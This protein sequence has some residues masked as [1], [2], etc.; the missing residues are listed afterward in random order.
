MKRL[1]VPESSNAL[2]QV[3]ADLDERLNRLWRHGSHM[4][5][6]WMEAGDGVAVL[7]APFEGLVDI[8]E[9]E[10]GW[11]IAPHRMTPDDMKRA[12][13]ALGVR[14]TK[15]PL[16]S[17]LDEHPGLAG[18]VETMMC[19]YGVARSQHRAGVMFDIVDF[20]KKSA[21]E[22]VLLIKNLSY[23]INVAHAR[24]SE[25][26]YDI[27]LGRA[28]TASGIMIWNRRNGL[29]ADIHLFYLMILTLADNALK[30]QGKEE[31]FIP[32]LRTVFH[33]GPVY[34]FHQPQGLAPGAFNL[35]FGGLVAAL[36]HVSALARPDQILATQFK[37]PVDPPPGS[38]QRR[39]SA[40]TPQFI[41]LAQREIDG[42]GDVLLE[43]E[44]VSA[45]KCYLTGR[46]IGGG[47]F[48]IL[49]Y[50]TADGLGQQHLLFNL[51]LNIHRPTAD[52]LYI[53]VQHTDLEDFAI[54]TIVYDPSQA[55]A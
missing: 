20:D 43:G 23:S 1:H 46:S 27:D 52:P 14:P 41:A 36:R 19:R 3:I 49:Q 51:K 54:E 38:M 6:G 31:D 50:R 55:E 47:A 11:L 40:D 44:K 12:A 22:Q 9:V 35:I 8:L 48:N 26:G 25:G 28:N 13:D 32:R 15:L 17:A 37:R 21:L 16:R 39:R 42:L 29:A 18:L 53:G 10:P 5:V 2:R 30:R 4:L 45:L 7:F 33:V 24:I 34:E